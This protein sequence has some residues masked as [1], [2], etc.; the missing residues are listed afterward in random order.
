MRTASID[1]FGVTYTLC[2]SARV[3]AAMEARCGTAQ[4]GINK[5]AKGN[6]TETFWLLS[7]MLEAGEAYDKMMDKEPPKPPT[8]DHLLTVLGRED[9]DNVYGAVADALT[10]G[11]KPTVEV[12]PPKKGKG[13]TQAE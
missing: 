9:F 11:N 8:H 7:Q 1:L 10:A 4:E 13:A 6:M 5:I 12:K 3:V 2:Y